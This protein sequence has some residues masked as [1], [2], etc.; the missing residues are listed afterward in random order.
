MAA[1][2]RYARQVADRFHPDRIILFGSFAYGTP[3]PDSDVDLMVVM[4]ARNQLD[5][6]VKISWEVP[7]PFPIDLL[8]CRPRE[9]ERRVAD[10]ESFIRTVRAKGKLLYEK[11]HPGVGE[12]GRGRSP[13]RNGTARRGA[14]AP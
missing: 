4:P 14:T 5:Q 11:G 6:A 13:R 9:W 8:V 2:R 3:N 7:A 10:D 1:I 12:E